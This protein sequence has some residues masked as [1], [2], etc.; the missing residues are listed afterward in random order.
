MSR[1]L[2]AL[3]DAV[4]TE[5]RFVEGEEFVGDSTLLAALDEFCATKSAICASR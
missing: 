4:Q 3:R 2:D 1:W 5:L